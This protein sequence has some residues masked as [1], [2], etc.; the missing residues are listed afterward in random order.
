MTQEV[1]VSIKP[2]EKHLEISNFGRVKRLASNT[3]KINR[4]KLGKAFLH[5]T[6]VEEK[7]LKQSTIRTGYSIIRVSI[8]GINITIRV[9]QEVAKAFVENKDNKPFVNHKDGNKLNN[10]YLNLEWCTVA[11]NNFHY[12][13]IKTEDTFGEVA[14]AFTGSVDA[15]R[16]DNN[17]FVCRMSGNKEMKDNGFDFRLVSAVLKGKRKSHKG[18][19][20][21]KNDDKLKTEVSVEQFSKTSF[22]PLNVY[23]KKNNFLFTLEDYESILYHKLTPQR[24]SDCLLGKS[25][26]HKGFIFKLQEKDNVIDSNG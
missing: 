23:D 4:S 10:F 6:K 26:Q 20:F 16:L 2:Y 22:K 25:K 1:W 18:C 5:N 11:E 21:I 14:K 17:E 19:Y 3:L 13:E 7:I 9:H 12:H 15:Y 8:E 24:V